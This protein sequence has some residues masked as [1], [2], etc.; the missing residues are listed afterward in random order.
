MLWP[1]KA[2]IGSNERL[3]FPSDILRSYSAEQRISLSYQARR[4]LDHRYS[5]N[6][7]E[8][9]V[10]YEL[11]KQNAP[12]P[13]EVPEWQEA[14]IVTVSSGAVAITVDTTASQFVAGGKAVLWRA[15]S[16]Y[17]VINVNT[18]S[19]T[20]ITLTGVTAATWTNARLMPLSVAYAPKGMDVTV[21]ASKHYECSI[22]WE[23]YA[24]QDLADTLPYSLFL[25]HPIISNACKVGSDSFSAR[26]IRNVGIINNDINQPYYDTQQATAIRSFGVAWIAS[27]QAELFALRK[28]FYYLRG[29][30]KTFW[31]PTYVPMTIRANASAGAS[32][33]Q[34]RGIG[35]LSGNLFAR[36]TDGQ[37]LGIRYT[38]AS[39]TTTQTL[40]LDE[41]LDLALTTESYLCKMLKARIN[42]DNIELAYLGNNK[43]KILIPCIEVPD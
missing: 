42:T 21:D 35:T 36:T 29:P 3:Q 19:P 22:K 5:I 31:L 38:A 34:I 7:H 10:A 14:K 13:F 23:A 9:D 40:V 30:V 39:G 17:E 37:E 43:T 12:G 18:V 11:M 32:S 6:A 15:S 1:F 20:G 27:N 4:L 8:L 41:P 24:N 25:G 16:S 26:I 28:A 33:L 2:I